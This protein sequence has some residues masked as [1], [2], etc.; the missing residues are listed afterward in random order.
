MERTPSSHLKP[1]SA[2]RTPRQTPR[3]TPRPT[4]G[5]V[6]DTIEPVDL[7]DDT[8][9]NP[10]SRSSSTTPFGN[11][12][13]LWTPG[14]A[15]RPEPLET[16]Q[17]PAWRGKKRKSNEISSRSIQKRTRPE[18]QLE[19]VYQG[20]LDD[21]MDID[22][23]FA[24]RS[25]H[26]QTPLKKRPV[27]QAQPNKDVDPANDFEEEDFQVTETI[28]RVETR[29]R[30]SISRV[31]S[32]S[33]ASSNS[34]R[35][36]PRRLPLVGLKDGPDTAISKKRTPE[37]LVARSPSSKLQREQVNG[38]HKTPQ[39]SNKC[40]RERVIQDSDEDDNFSI[41]LQAS[42]TSRSPSKGN[43]KVVISRRSPKWDGIPP[44][45]ASGTA[46]NSP[47]M[48]RQPLG[49]PL[50]PISCNLGSR[51]DSIPSPLDGVPPT[52]ITPSSNANPFSSQPP[53][54][55]PSRND[56]DK[57]ALALFLKQPSAIA[58]YQLR[59]RNLKQQSADA[60]MDYL[61]RLEPPPHELQE[62]RRLLVVK[63][64]AYSVLESLRDNHAK[65]N[66]EK[67]RL[68]KLISDAPEG[69]DTTSDDESIAMIVQEI[70]KIGREII[71][72]LHL[73]GAVEDGF[74]TG[75]NMGDT[76]SIPICP[77]KGTGSGSL[78]QGSGIVGSAQVVFQTQ[79]PS[80]KQY[81]ITTADRPLRGSPMETVAQ[82][83]ELQ[84]HPV[85]P[86]RSSPSPVRNATYRS[87][88]VRDPIYSETN[89]IWAT[90][91]TVSRRPNF[92]R[93][94]F[95][96][97]NI[98]TAYDDTILDEFEN[99]VPSKQIGNTTEAVAMSED[100]FWEQGDDS[101]MLEVAQQV[102]HR[103]SIS[104]GAPRSISPA[105]HRA[106][107]RTYAGTETDMYALMSVDAAR[108]GG[109]LRNKFS[110]DIVK[111]LK[112]RFRL[113]GFRHNQLNAMN[114]TLLGQDVFVLM[115][116]G[117]GK[118][119]C[120]QLPAIVQSGKTKGI[121]VV[122]SPLLS[123]MTD[124]VD[125]LR[126]INVR[127]ATLNGE[128]SRQDRAE[129]MHHLR[130]THPEQYLQLLYITPEMA[131]KSDALMDALS[132]VHKN[133]KLARIV[134]DEAHC[135]SQ[136]GHDFR[137]DYVAL[138]HVRAKFPGVPIMALTATATSNVQL[139]VETNLKMVNPK[140]FTQSFNRPNLYYEVR[141]KKGKGSS[142]A[143]LEDMAKL[144]KSKYRNQS[145]II[146]SLSRKGC[147]QLAE[148]LRK[149]HKLDTAHFH[150]D[151]PTDEKA[152]VQRNWQSGAIQV[153]VATIAF[154][155][156]IDKRDVRFIIHH[157][158]PKTLEGYYQETGR[159]GRDGAPSGCYLYYGFQDTAILRDFIKNSEGNDDQ[160][161]RQYLMLRNMVQYCENRSDCR[162]VE[163][164][165][166]FNE[167]NFNKDG[168][169]GMCDNC[170]S[171]AVFETV[172][173]TTQA[174]HAVELVKKLQDE[175]VTL[176]HCIDILQGKSSPKIKKMAHESL[177]E[178]GIASSIARGEVERIF[179]RLVMDN[180]LVEYSVTNKVG[181]ATQY[182]K[183]RN[184][185][186]LLTRLY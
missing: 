33:E 149:E 152:A 36:S 147:E 4:S 21:F 80:V 134:I 48:R 18:R 76:S 53:P 105:P 159:A 148:E 11:T 139:D 19:E 81:S 123:L 79:V 22:D 61:D 106:S 99:D 89:D 92:V 52:K 73:S 140:K 78:I 112:D 146:Y 125:H 172:D 178:Y 44:W 38:L 15:S 176:I 104:F 133:R 118:S 32:L 101:A 17:S 137:P 57:R 145:G 121:T 103:H 124:Q 60:C 154:G 117:G 165:R 62:E 181:F 144:I 74:G 39:K 45:E 107:K 13:V 69:A 63:D 151:M 150:A 47:H 67:K 183:V 9:E 8:V 88:F 31:P 71:R 96:D 109:L 108:A 170:K 166:Y 51:Q 26:S 56:A 164:L 6:L 3:Q 179:Y 35:E 174:Q 157:T 184:P 12:T 132:T 171:D 23:M 43:P 131:N 156:G 160:K 153:V 167:M 162:R 1:V 75:S 77:S 58:S 37:L 40:N 30:K 129:I 169:H 25:Q 95:T 87:N 10:T 28:R 110:E 128:V 97:D 91:G 46:M 49:S 98:E 66:L 180:A 16:S 72:Q 127:A 55:S 173:F 94:R 130:E 100:E 136:W 155:M 29:T 50:K 84:H 64:A 168:C 14:A 54:S 115:P 163:V 5:L 114:A 42:C 34:R 90:S 126:K 122:I 143:V 182:V 68:A 120:Y 93:D 116:T 85:A 83:F 138:G 158:V 119:L 113:T 135:V 82:P 185:I 20:D 86:D 2:P 186:Y 177:D 142:K 7:T 41:D 65:L 111:V 141:K 102:E 175:N 59:V 27:R 161:E 70:V 24:I